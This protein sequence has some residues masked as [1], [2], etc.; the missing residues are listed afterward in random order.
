MIR[1]IK[2]ITAAFLVL[3]PLF[4]PIQQASAE[5]LNSAILKVGKNQRYQTIQAAIDASSRFNQ[6][7]ILVEA[8]T[9][10][11]KLF[12]TR[13][14]LAIVGQSAENTIVRSSI[15]RSTWR[16][17]HPNDWG[18]A[19]VNINARDISL[20]NLTVINDYGRNHN[21]DEHQFAVRGFEQSDR[22]ITHNC[23]LIADGADTLSLWNK[24][25][26]YYHSHCYV[27]GYVDMVC[28]RGS[29][30]I[31]DS[32]FFNKKQSATLWHDG[33]L[34]ADYKFVVNRSSFDGIDGFWLGR[35]HY[36]AQ[37][38]LLN[39]R[40]SERMADKPIFRKRYPQTPERER[41][42]LYG[43]RYFFQG[44]EFPNNLTWLND[45]FR[46]NDA[47]ASEQSSLASWVFDGQWQPSE[48]LKNL[49][50]QLDAAGL[51]QTIQ[52]FNY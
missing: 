27:E 46:L 17:S 6:A 33:E 2:P 35:H 31:E 45:N 51:Y 30:L 20:I 5:Q 43:S 12:I 32:I 3:I 50:Q 48:T 28:P 9:Y 16:G 21:T 26:R 42:N 1:M 47:L 19:V 38:Y 41:A 4:L 7:I 13:N 49:Q 24:H 34:N 23:K 40:F 8:G 44:N 37:F 22:I 25:G 11:E 15:L 36:D 52:P 14:N 39:S 18:A 10:P 29:A